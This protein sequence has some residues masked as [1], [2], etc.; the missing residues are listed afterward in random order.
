[1]DQG[2][3]FFIL[4]A[5]QNAAALDGEGQSRGDIGLKDVGSVSVKGNRCTVWLLLSAAL[6]HT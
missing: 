1:M 4:V 6:S 3:A 2:I 5:I